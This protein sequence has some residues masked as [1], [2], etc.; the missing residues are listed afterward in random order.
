MDQFKKINAERRLRCP[1]EKLYQ[2][3]TL[4]RSMEVAFCR[5]CGDP[6]AAYYVAGLTRCN[7][8]WEVSR[9]LAD[10]VK[11]FEGERF[12]REIL[13]TNNLRCKNSS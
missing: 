10:F 5:F 6:A 13:E 4:A 1:P 2:F 11:T 3:D 7:G 8:C 9:R 12:V